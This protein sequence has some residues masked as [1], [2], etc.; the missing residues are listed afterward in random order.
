MLDNI[1][2]CDIIFSDIQ[3]SER[4]FS[5]S[6]QDRFLEDY[7]RDRIN[8]LLREAE[9]VRLARRA[10]PAYVPPLGHLLFNTGGWLVRCGDWLQ[11]RYATPTTIQPELG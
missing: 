10:K 3:I 8:T 6:M 11:R 7:G 1:N 2:F 9:Q 5:M 4:I